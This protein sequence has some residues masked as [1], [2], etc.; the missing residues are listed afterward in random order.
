MFFR[1]AFA[2]AQQRLSSSLASRNDPTAFI[3]ARLNWVLRHGTRVNQLVIRPDGYVRVNDIRSCWSF[4]NV[5]PEELNAF[6]HLAARGRV[7]YFH[8]VQEY[9]VRVGGPSWWIRSIWGHS[10]KTVDITARKVLSA[11]E[12]PLA[13]FPTGLVAGTRAAQ[14]GILPDDDGLIHLR[15]TTPRENFNYGIGVHFPICIYVDVEKMLSSGI[16][17]FLTTRGQVLT[18]GDHTNTIPPSFFTDVVRIKF[19]KKTIWKPLP[20]KPKT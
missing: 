10:I 16:L 1:R 18:T 13:V 5:E 9:D 15:R 19:S 20:T 8:V 2:L 11:A 6:L 3:S 12:V 7:K 4:R 17:L 14:D